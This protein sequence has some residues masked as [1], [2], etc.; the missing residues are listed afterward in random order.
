MPR[1]DNP[2]SRKN[3]RPLEKGLPKEDQREVQRKGSRAGVEKRIEYASLTEAARGIVGPKERDELITM[4]YKR[5]KLG[6]LKAYELLRDQLGEK[7]VE[8][9]QVAQ[10]DTGTVEE[11]DNLING[12][13]EQSAEND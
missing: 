6:N 8:K 5:A 3:L 13:I 12:I 2:N 1:G 9:I 11:I 10:I 4:L 7:P